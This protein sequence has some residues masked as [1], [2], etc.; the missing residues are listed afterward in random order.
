MIHEHTGRLSSFF[1]PKI[2]IDY[3]TDAPNRRY[4]IED[5]SEIISAIGYRLY[6]FY[7]NCLQMSTN[8]SF[9]WQL[10]WIMILICLF[11]FFRIIP[12][13]WI[14]IILTNG[15]LIIPGLIFHPSI[16][17]KI[18]DNLDMIMLFLSSKKDI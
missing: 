17:P 3:E 13:L 18:K 12:T 8:V 5:L 6:W 14:N 9:I 7:Q 15:I 2:P 1:F 16:Y 11:I 4:Y 10:L